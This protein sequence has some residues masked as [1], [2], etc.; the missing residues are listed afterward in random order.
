M[1]RGSQK[2]RD[3]DGV[4]VSISGFGTKGVAG[5]CG[6]VKWKGFVVPIFLGRR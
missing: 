3:V 5:P 1:E 2:R 4:E 6:F